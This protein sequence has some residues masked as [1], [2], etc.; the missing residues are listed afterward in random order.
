[1]FSY[2]YTDQVLQQLRAVWEY[3]RVTNY[4]LYERY[5]G[6][7]HPWENTVSKAMRKQ[8]DADGDVEFERF[9][10]PANMAYVLVEEAVGYWAG[11]EV[12][13]VRLQSGRAGYRKE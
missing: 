11:A 12:F 8:V 10:K 5:Y 6:G 4:A 9:W 2:S 3:S 1:M 7:D 13:A